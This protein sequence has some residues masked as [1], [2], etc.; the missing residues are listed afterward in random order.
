MVGKKKVCIKSVSGNTQSSISDILLKIEKI[1]MEL[2]QMSGN[3][4]SV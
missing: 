4:I 1:R 2:K 3:E